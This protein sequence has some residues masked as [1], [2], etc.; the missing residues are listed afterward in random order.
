[1]EQQQQQCEE[2]HNGQ[3]MLLDD[4]GASTVGDWLEHLP[5]P[6]CDSQQPAISSAGKDTAS[7]GA[8]TKASFEPGES[9][10]PIYDL[11]L[12]SQLMGPAVELS[13]DSDFFKINP[14]NSEW[15][16]SNENML[17]VYDD[18]M[19]LLGNHMISSSS[20]NPVIEPQHELVGKVS[21][22]I[23]ECDKDTLQH[24]VNMLRGLKGKAKLEID[25]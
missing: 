11:S 3:A 14:D 2:T 19:A 10:E 7:S 18:P 21:L 23:D 16:E 17:A 5:A 15:T 24:L 20:E 4:W 13:N 8:A 1:M 12:P 6:S 25:A 9:S 22:V